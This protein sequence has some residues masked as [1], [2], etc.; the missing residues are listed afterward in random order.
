LFEP[1]WSE[2]S[3]G[4]GIG[5]YQARQLAAGAGGSLEVI[6]SGDRPLV[7]VLSLPR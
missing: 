7:F 6:A 1:F 5:L 3:K 4:L 2:Q